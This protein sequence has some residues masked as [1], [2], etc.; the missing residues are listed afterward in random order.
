MGISNESISNSITGI[1]KDLRQKKGNFLD[2]HFKFSFENE[3]FEFISVS[4]FGI[5]C[6]ELNNCEY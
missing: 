6:W 1:I 4:M 3:S 5:E 2:S